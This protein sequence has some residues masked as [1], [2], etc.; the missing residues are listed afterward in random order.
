MYQILKNTL[1]TSGIYIY[2]CI[3]NVYTYIHT[4]IYIFDMASTPNDENLKRDKE[5]QW[6]NTNHI[7]TGKMWLREGR[8][9]SFG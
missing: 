7:G 2:I 9:V 4:Y 3:C 6:R 1:Y 5:E 8:Q